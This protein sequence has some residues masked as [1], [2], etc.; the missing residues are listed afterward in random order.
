[1][2]ECLPKPNSLGAN[3]K[4][5]IDLSNY[6]IKTYLKETTGLDTTSFAKKIDLAHLE[7]HVDKLDLDF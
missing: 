3:L 2:G 4:V 5:E 1:M 7:F 6:A